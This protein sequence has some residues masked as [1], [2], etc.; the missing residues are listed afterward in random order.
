MGIRHLSARFALA[1]WIAGGGIG[2]AAAQ[3]SAR[4]PD[5]PTVAPAAAAHHRLW[6]M[7]FDLSSMD[8]IDVGRARAAADRWIES[9]LAGDDL[10]AVVTETTTVQTPQNFTEDVAK[11]RTAVAAI[12][13][14]EPGT[15]AAPDV[16]ERDYF[17]NDLRYRG[18]RQLCT[19]LQSIEQKKA[20]MLFT[21]VRERPGADNQVEV[22]AATDACGRANTSV[23]PID[24][25]TAR[26]VLPRR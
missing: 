24:V 6:V 20:I 12:R 15:G 23:N 13:P 19:G 17:N 9:A 7:L 5:T 21:A 4:T 16:D 25:R 11:L 18:L 8:A 1:A 2:L 10:V 26:S 14:F 22:R 3:R